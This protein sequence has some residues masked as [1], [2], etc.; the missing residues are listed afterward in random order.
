[1]NHNRKY[2]KYVSKSIHHKQFGGSDN[3]INKIIGD[4]K[5]QIDNIIKNL[6]CCLEDMKTITTTNDFQQQFMKRIM[7]LFSDKI[8]AIENIKYNISEPNNID[9]IINKYCV[10]YVIDICNI[11][12]KMLEELIKYHNEDMNKIPIYNIPS[13]RIE[14]KNQKHANLL[15]VLKSS[16]Q[17]IKFDKLECNITDA[18][19]S[20]YMAVL[21]IFFI[22]ITSLFQNLSK[23]YMKNF[24]KSIN[25]NNI[26][27]SIKEFNTNVDNIYLYN[28]NFYNNLEKT[29]GREEIIEKY[30]EIDEI[31]QKIVHTIKIND[32][33]EN[34][35]LERT[36][37]LFTMDA[38]YKPIVE[39][40]TKIF[41]LMKNHSNIQKKFGELRNNKD[42][43]EQLIKEIIKIDSDYETKWK[44]I[45]YKEKK[46]NEE[47]KKALSDLEKDKIII[48]NKF[49][50][51]NPERIYENN[52]DTIN[53]TYKDR[54]LQ[55]DREK[56]EIKG[57]YKT[58]LDAL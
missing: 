37:Y 57:K 28:N 39:L 53:K 18:V 1:M 43:L 36:N 34:Q 54:Y 15:I 30:G 29:I 46:L 7:Q 31:K 48:F 25:F 8:Q 42:Q 50:N 12:N 10:P 11:S 45:L 58:Q 16:D 33:T 24:S 4:L 32:V 55:L 19:S 5:N 56:K 41:N 2:I 13:Y 3:E 17:I 40:N 22:R 52:K 47:E 21:S 38:T 35:T 51:A 14:L 49:R 6:K 20:C 23:E 9:S 26:F 44:N 27:D